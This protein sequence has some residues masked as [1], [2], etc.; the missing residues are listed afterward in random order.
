G[1]GRG[2]GGSA[3]RVRLRSAMPKRLRSLSRDRAAG[4]QAQRQPHGALLARGYRPRFEQCQRR[5]GLMVVLEA[6]ELSK[7]FRARRGLF[8]GDRGV[9][10]G[11]GGVWFTIG[12]ARRL[13][14]GGGSGCGEREA[15][16]RVVRV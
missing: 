6:A 11:V 4:A 13:G 10:R 2:L 16:G 12:G 1:A 14:G 3:A 8:G 7:H 5:S 15:R 9:V